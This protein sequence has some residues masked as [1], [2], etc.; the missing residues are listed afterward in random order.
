MT[1]YKPYSGAGYSIFVT[2]F[3]HIE[4][5]IELLIMRDSIQAQFPV[6]LSNIACTVKLTKSHF[7][8]IGTLLYT[9]FFL[10]Q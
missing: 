7:I 9:L 8:K 2:L 10:M 4:L 5:S 3:V 6:N 1:F